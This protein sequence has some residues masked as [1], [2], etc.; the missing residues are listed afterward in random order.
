MSEVRAPITVLMPVHRIDP[1][2][3]ESAASIELQLNPNDQFLIVLNGPALREIDTIQA[4]FLGKKE[5]EVHASF[6]LG[7][8]PALNLGLAVA[9][10]EYIARMDADD[11]SLSGRLQRQADFLDRHKEIGVVGTQ[12]QIICQHG[13]RLRKTHLP[14]RLRSHR[15]KPLSP[16]V[17][18]PSVMFR[19]TVI[20]LAGGYRANYPHAED[21]D[22]WTRVL[23]KS[24]IANLRRPYLSY[25]THQSQISALNIQSQA[26]ETLAVIL[27]DLSM[28]GQS[29][30]WSRMYCSYWEFIR[31]LLDE[32]VA[33]KAKICVR[34]PH[35]VLWFL[36]THFR[37][38]ISSLVT[39][40]NTCLQ[41]SLLFDNDL[42]QTESRVI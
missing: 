19:K 29:L 5:V 32:P 40:P 14:S 26:S 33:S 25:R 3:W 30:F 11:I 23:E 1:F 9:T 36:L 28:H 20:E 4:H 35:L 15:M 17:I 24:D 12:A 39:R 34:K 42:A 6:D 27:D 16:K 10:H 22:L 37:T 7:I 18:H 13:T 8:V 2:F 31:V 21:H 38:I 41:C